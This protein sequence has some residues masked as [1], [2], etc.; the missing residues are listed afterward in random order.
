MQRGLVITFAASA[1][2][3]R[4]RAALSLML[5][6]ELGGRKFSGVSAT[7]CA[8]AR[9]L[10]SVAIH[11]A[12]PKLISVDETHMKCLFAI[13]AT[14]CRLT[15][16]YEAQ[17]SMVSVGSAALQ[18]IIC[19]QAWM[20]R[21]QRAV[22]HVRRVKNTASTPAG[23]RRRSDSSHKQ[24]AR[25]EREQRRRSGTYLDAS[26]LSQ[27]ALREPATKHA[28]GQDVCLSRCFG[29]AG[30]VPPGNSAG[31]PKKAACEAP[32]STAPRHRP[33]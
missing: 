19:A 30:R 21:L 31:R 22:L 29:I 3:A 11:V 23:P 32:G 8:H 1:N 6:N 12:V 16:T 7:G 26:G 27:L 28:N 9:Q 5:E 13:T 25:D 10:T 33:Q 20:G 15:L 18:E 2:K 4:E 24:R 17:R 14:P